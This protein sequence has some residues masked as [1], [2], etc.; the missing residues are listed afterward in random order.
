MLKK[1]PVFAGIVTAITV[2]ACAGAFFYTKYFGVIIRPDVQINPTALP[3]YLQNDPAWRDD[4]MGSTKYTLA[5]HGCLVS[6]L[7]SSLSGLGYSLD[8]GRLNTVFS[9]KQVYDNNGNVIWN[10][11]HR[12]FPDVGYSYERLFTA[13]TIERELKNGGWP[14]VKVKFRGS[15]VEHWV[16]IV[17]STDED[18]L[19]IDPMQQ[20]KKLI[21]LSVHGKVYAYR[22]LF[23]K[24]HPNRS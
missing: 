19:I 8:A 3:F 16:L 14:I 10:R 22:I 24:R 18:F 15:G 4:R 23:R 17:G 9:E 20:N 12:C 5:G 7:A 11:I 21:S 13:S 1:I 6:V 2:I